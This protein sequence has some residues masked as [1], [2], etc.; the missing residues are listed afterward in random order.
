MIQSRNLENEGSKIK[1]LS[2]SVRNELISLTYNHVLSDTLSE[3]EKAPF[4][5]LILDTT[6]DIAKHN[7]RTSHTSQA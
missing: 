2:T 5:S 4:F 1:Y 3:A 6:Q 7:S